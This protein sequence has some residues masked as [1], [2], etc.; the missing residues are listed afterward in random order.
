[1]LPPYTDRN[2]EVFLLPDPETW[3]AL[4]GLVAM[5]H[6]SLLCASQSGYQNLRIYSHF[7][8]LR[9]SGSFLLDLWP[10]KG[11]GRIVGEMLPL[12]PIPPLRASAKRSFLVMVFVEAEAK[13]RGG[14]A[15]AP[16]YLGI[17]DCTEQKPLQTGRF[18]RTA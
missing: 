7:L 2:R 13:S 5:R 4:G 11:W 8:Y 15:L 12:W 9:S 1:M 10:K 6:D 14:R 16:W 17:R 18:H 3:A